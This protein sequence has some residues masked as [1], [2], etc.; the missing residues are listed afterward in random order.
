MGF[1]PVLSLF[2]SNL[3]L[4]CEK[5]KKKQNSVTIS[6]CIKIKRTSRMVTT[7]RDRDTKWDVA[8]GCNYKITKWNVP[9]DNFR[10]RVDSICATKVNLSSSLIFFV[11]QTWAYAR[12]QATA[13]HTQEPQRSAS[14][15]TSRFVVDLLHIFRVKRLSRQCF[16]NFSLFFYLRDPL[17][18]PSSFSR[19]HI[20][21]RYNIHVCPMDRFVF[22]RVCQLAHCG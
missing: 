14:H 5:E 15:C 4:A 10:K 9:F 1:V 20:I 22:Y 12:A 16:S 8:I 21:H 2:L 18:R 3:F 11:G 19:T 13:I 7:N 6:R 17:P